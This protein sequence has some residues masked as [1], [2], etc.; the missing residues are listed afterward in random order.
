MLLMSIISSFTQRHAF[1]LVD[2]SVMPLA[3]SISALTLTTGSV[4]YFHGYNLGLQTT[5]FGFFSVLTCMFI[6]WRDIVREG[7]LEGYHTNIVQLG[8]RY[9]VIL[10]IVS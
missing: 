8:L 5:L 1:H 6:W 3:S 9:A 10:F 7:T 2:P 4:L